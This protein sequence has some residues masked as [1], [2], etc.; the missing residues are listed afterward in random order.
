MFHRN[1][2]SFA[3]IVSFRHRGVWDAQE[4]VTNYLSGN[5]SKPLTRLCG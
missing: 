4:H 3:G 5:P 2:I 1:E